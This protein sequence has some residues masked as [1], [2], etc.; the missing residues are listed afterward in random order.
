MRA[1][2]KR[3]SVIGTAL[4]LVLAAGVV[5]A[6][7][8]APPASAAVGCSYFNGL[9]TTGVKADFAGVNLKTGDVIKVTVSPARDT[10]KI[11]LSTAVN[12]YLWFGPSSPATSGYSWSAPS[13]GSYNLSYA[14]TSTA[15]APVSVA[16]S[17]T[18]TCSSTTVSP[19]PTPTPTTTTKP[20]K[21]GGKGK[22]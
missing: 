1:R 16:W 9:N 18:A 7:M 12:Q 3:F 15:G 6:P 20:G 17:F 10:D 13:D 14:L 11:Y 5:V 4:G 19:S 2:T 8:A 22:G 21:G